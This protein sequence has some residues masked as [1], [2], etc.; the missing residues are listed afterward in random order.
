MGQ[1]ADIS[2]ICEFSWYSWV[3]YN[4]TNV[5]F[6]DVKVCLGRYLGP[7][8]PEVGSVLTAKIL[9]PNGKVIQRK[10][11]RHLTRQE[12]DSDETRKER[13]TF[14]ASVATELGEA[15]YDML[16]VVM[17]EQVQRP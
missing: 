3:Y 4:E 12:F 16:T 15:V 13:E 1:T 7:T 9:K 8:E 2:F 5:Q 11:F 14:D 6:P 10:R 17:A